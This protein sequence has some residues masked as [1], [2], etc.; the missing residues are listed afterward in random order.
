MDRGAWQNIVQMVTKSQTR[1]KWLSTHFTLHLYI[2]EKAAFLIPHES[3]SASF[4][5]PFCRFLSLHGIEESGP[6]CGLGF[7]LMNVVGSL[8]AQRVK[9]LPAMWETQVQS[10]GSGRSPGEGN[11]NPL[12]YSCLENSMDGKAW[13]A[14]AHGISES[15]TRLNDF[16]KEYCGWF[17]LL[18]RPLK[19]SPQQQVCW[20]SYHLHVHQ[21]S[22]FNFPQNCLHSQLDCL[23]QEAYLSAYLDFQHVFLTK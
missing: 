7:G 3:T 1:L 20:L 23:Q 8:V 16:L 13:Q 19:L 12:Q 17:D 2:I 18:Y 11:G 6:W 9:C 4:I 22:P 10:Q 21:S 14:T 15:R 5:L